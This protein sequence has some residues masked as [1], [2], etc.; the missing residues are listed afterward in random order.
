VADAVRW[1]NPWVRAGAAQRRRRPERSG[2]Q[3][4][5]LRNNPHKQFKCSV[6]RSVTL[7]QSCTPPKFCNKATR[8]QGC[9][10]LSLFRGPL[11][12]PRSTLLSNVYALLVPFTWRLNAGFRHRATFR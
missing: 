2:G 4:H 11:A 8:Q 9:L 6:K 1:T 3:S 10:A 5:P 12:A 7:L